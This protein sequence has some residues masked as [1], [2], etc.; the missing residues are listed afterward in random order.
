MELRV[1]G[2]EFSE[3]VGDQLSAISSRVDTAIIELIAD[4]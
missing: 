4:G 3:A 1:Q 2:S